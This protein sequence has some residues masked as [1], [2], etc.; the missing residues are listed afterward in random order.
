MTTVL[1]IRHASCEPVGRWLAGRRPGIHLDEAGRAQA[2]ALAD[3]LAK[4]E[5][6]AIASSPLERAMETVAPLAE[7]LS[8]PIMAEPDLLEIDFGE[9]TG[10]T[11]E[12]LETDPRWRRFN[13]ARSVSPIP[14]GE[15]MLGV[16]ARAVG[17]LERWRR[18]SGDATIALCS[19]ADL[20]R[21]LIV[22]YLGMPLD[23]I[24]R[25]EIAPASVTTLDLW[26]TGARVRTLGWTAGGSM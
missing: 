21:A 12:A 16:Q 8:L 17:C 23:F 24:H 15:S 9:W 22:H 5:I 25:I 26:E 11:L 3:E 18:Q 13:E 7:R 1:L 4:V 10:C 19:H 2:R 20:L 6:A 14:G